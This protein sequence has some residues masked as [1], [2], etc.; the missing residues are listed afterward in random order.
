[1]QL[2]CRGIL[3]ALPEDWYVF[4][5][6]SSMLQVECFILIY[7]FSIFF[8]RAFWSMFVVVALLSRSY[9]ALRR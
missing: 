9:R 7:K 4:E 1:L 5:L 2:Q 6:T 8:G 3:D